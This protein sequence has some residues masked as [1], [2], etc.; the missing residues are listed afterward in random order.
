MPAFLHAILRRLDLPV[1]GGFRF[2]ARC[3]PGDA[4]AKNA[5]Q[6]DDEFV[7][8]E[9]PAGDFCRP[10]CAEAAIGRIGEQREK[11]PESICARAAVNGIND[12]GSFSPSICANYFRS[13][14]PRFRIIRKTIANP[15]SAS[16]TSSTVLETPI[17]FISLGVTYTVTDLT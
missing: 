14:P 3:P 9:R 11:E 10:Q 15:T 2:A 8:A 5:F 7:V 17:I 6:P 12:S 13:A 16:P 1:V 4:S